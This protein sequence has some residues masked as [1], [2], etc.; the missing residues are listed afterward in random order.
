MELIL[1]F[2]LTDVVRCEEKRGMAKLRS[3]KA[4]ALTYFLTISKPP[5][6][7]DKHKVLIYAG[8]RMTH[9]LGSHQTHHKGRVNIMPWVPSRSPGVKQNPKN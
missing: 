3:F 8:S 4:C 6:P 9:I 7:H 5:P 2:S 1:Y